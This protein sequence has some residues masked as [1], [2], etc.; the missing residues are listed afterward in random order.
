[1]I[2]N[3]DICHFGTN[4]WFNYKIDVFGPLYQGLFDFCN[5]SFRINNIGNRN[6]H[7]LVGIDVL[8]RHPKSAIEL[9]RAAR[10][11]QV[12]YSIFNVENINETS[13]NGRVDYDKQVLVDLIEAADFTVSIFEDSHH[14]LSSINSR[15]FYFHWTPSLFIPKSI[16]RRPERLPTIFFNGLLKGRRKE[17]LDNLSRRLGIDIQV[18]DPRHPFAERL[19]LENSGMPAISIESYG[20]GG[21]VNPFRFATAFRNQRLILHNHSTDPDSY[22]FSG[23]HFDQITSKEM[24][25][26]LMQQAFDADQ[27]DAMMEY[28]RQFLDQIKMITEFFL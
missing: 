25:L 12:S 26:S 16:F 23:V 28:H 18:V 15:G 19:V 21:S 4:D 8:V 7:I 5:P 17:D 9:I 20:H 11:K 13:I 27:Q 6:H 2:K 1:M 10:K 3:I 14:Y 24:I 22:I